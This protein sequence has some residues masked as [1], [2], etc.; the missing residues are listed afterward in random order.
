MGRVSRPH[1]LD[2]TLSIRSYAESESSF[3]RAGRVVL[4]TDAGERREYPVAAARPH[5]KGVLLDLDGLGS[6]EEAERF[7]GA[8]IHVRREDL[9]S[10][11][12]DGYYWFELVG[13]EVFL[14][15]GR[16]IGTLARILPTGGSDVYVVESGKREILIPATREVIEEIDLDRKRITVSEM[17]GLLD[18]N[19]V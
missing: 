14:D 11:E 1:G 18:L 6:V 3:V 16:H 13:L 4:V 10:D 7:R 17:E 9:E 19:E 2:G 8:R 15:D 5:K 12:D